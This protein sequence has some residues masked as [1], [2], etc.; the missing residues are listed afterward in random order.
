MCNFSVIP[1]KAG[2]H[3]FIMDAS[4]SCFHRNDR[5]LEEVAHGVKLENFLNIG[6]SGFWVNP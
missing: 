6:N 3:C 1:A 5:E 4:D 2:I